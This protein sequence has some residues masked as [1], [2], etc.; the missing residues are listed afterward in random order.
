MSSTTLS[1]GSRAALR[2]VAGISAAALWL[3]VCGWVT[4]VGYQLSNEVEDCVRMSSEASPISV[5]NEFP[6]PKSTCSFERADG[7]V[8]EKTDYQ[9]AWIVVAGLL[10]G[11]IPAATFV[12]L[13]L[14]RP[15]PASSS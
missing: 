6:S 11:V 8:F 12:W 7:S 9:N 14:G 15:H 5:E 10:I 1:P 3:L 2:L 4:Y 13:G